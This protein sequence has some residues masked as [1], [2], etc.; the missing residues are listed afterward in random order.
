MSTGSTP[1]TLG[2]SL[3]VA[4]SDSLA[5]LSTNGLTLG[6]KCFVEA[7]AAYF[8]LGLAT[9][10]LDDNDVPAQGLSNG[11]WTED[12]TGDW[13]SQQMAHA[14]SLG[15][16]IDCAPYFEDFGLPVAPSGEFTQTYQTTFAQWLA[17]TISYQAQYPSGVVLI[18]ANGD[19][20]PN[21]NLAFIWSQQACGVLNT[22]SWYVCS[23]VQPQGGVATTADTQRILV[24]AC[25]S[26][27]FVQFAMLTEVQGGFTLNLHNQLNVGNAVAGGTV[28]LEN[29][30][31]YAVHYNHATD[32]I[33]A[34]CDHQPI[35]GLA[36]IPNAGQYLP[37][38]PANQGGTSCAVFGN[39]SAPLLADKLAFLTTSL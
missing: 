39:G 4:D 32:T 1:R 24:A 38:D 28:D 10:P 26:W 19:G 6:T 18:D 12:A 16:G 8:T 35:P 17:G 14:Q 2:A 27:D 33:T 21:D 22:R 3:V 34:Y 29:A 9:G 37:S 31:D 25:M 15:T 7:L 11:V 13:L 23:R 36:S 30:H 5:A 20:T